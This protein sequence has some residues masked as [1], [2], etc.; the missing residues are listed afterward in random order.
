VAL[1]GSTDPDRD[2]RALVAF[3]DGLL[4]DRL[5]GG[6]VATAPP[7]GTPESREQLRHAVQAALV[8]VLKG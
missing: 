4:F 7:P 3:I 2:S 6:G 5:A 1:A 8:G